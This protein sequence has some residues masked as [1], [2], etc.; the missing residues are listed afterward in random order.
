MRRVLKVNLL[1]RPM[2]VDTAL[3]HIW[4]MQP[5]HDLIYLDFFSQPTLAAHLPAL[6][7]IFSLG[8]G[9]LKQGGKLLLTFGR[10]RCRTQARDLN[11]ALSRRGGWRKVPLHFVDVALAKTGH[12]KYARC[13]IHDYVSRSWQFVI[14]EVDF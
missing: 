1:A 8:G 14:T 10:N 5:K 11:Q 6:D 13:R 12:R 3:D 7:R 2:D 4:V 9:M